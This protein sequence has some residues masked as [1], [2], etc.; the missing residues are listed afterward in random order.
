MIFFLNIIEIGAFAP[1]EQSKCSFFHII[2]KNIVN[3]R[4]YGIK[5]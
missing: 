1:K 3:R 2:F 4:Y 5:G